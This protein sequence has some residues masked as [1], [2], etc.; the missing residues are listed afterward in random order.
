MVVEQA[1]KLITY[2]ESGQKNGIRIVSYQL[3]EGKT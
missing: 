3:T 2:W 1:E